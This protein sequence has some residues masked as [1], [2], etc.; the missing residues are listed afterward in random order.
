MFQSLKCQQSVRTSRNKMCLIAGGRAFHSVGPDTEKAR[1]PYRSRWYRGV[2]NRCLSA[3]LSVRVGV[4]GVTSDD[5]YTGQRWYT[6]QYTSKRSLNSIR[7]RTGNQCRLN[8]TGVMWSR[9]RVPVISRAAEFWTICS[10]RSIFM[11]AHINNKIVNS[12]Y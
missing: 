7:W 10:F 3:D 8:K 11:H 5:W 4:Y 12:T 9:L 2:V 1:R 6:A